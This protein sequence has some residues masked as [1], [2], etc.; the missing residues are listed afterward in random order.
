MNGGILLDIETLLHGIEYEGTIDKKAEIANVCSDSRKVGRGSAFVCIK[1]R[2]YDGHDAACRALEAGAALIVSERP[3][4]LRGEITVRDTRLA[5]ARMCQNF[6]GNPQNKLRLV[7]VTG[8]NGKT[9]VTSIVKQAL[10]AMGHKA[11]LIGTIRCEIGDI[12]IPAKFTTPEAWDCAAL[13]ARM[14]AS[15]CEYAVMEASSQA[16]DQGRLLGLRFDCAVFTNLTGDHLDYHGTMEQYY[17]AKKLLFAQADTAVLNIDDD[18]G[19]RLCG[20]L[21][22]PK[23]TFSACDD[24]ADYTAKSIDCTAGGVR[25]ALNGNGFLERMH[26]P[27]PGLYSVHNAMSAACA[28][29]ALG[30]DRAAACAAVSGTKG[31]RGRCEVLHSGDATVIC[32]FAHTGDGLRQL[33]SSLRPFAKGRLVVL[34]GCAGDRDA[35]KRP[36]MAKAVCDYA[37]F[38]ILTS[39]NPRTE[40]PLGIISEVQPFIKASGIPYTAQPDR[41]YA[42]RWALENLH[43]DDL[44]VLCGK[45]HEDYQVIDGCTIYLDEHRIVKDFFDEKTGGEKK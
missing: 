3:L 19:R 21:P 26:F 16:L 9:T 25:F 39:D 5:Y 44:L 35:T 31:V 45:G 11:G 20:E 29:F 33:L 43:K 6:F 36:A 1:G 40:D 24:G 10:C 14:A 12:E 41:F 34:F 30:F 17:Q 27:M 8:T 7:A 38:I 15:G 28:L 37:D 2:R 4:G 13:L 22:I 18:Y 42:I 23:I 32:D